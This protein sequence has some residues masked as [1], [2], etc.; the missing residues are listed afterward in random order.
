MPTR[1]ASLIALLC[2]T[3]IPASAQRLPTIVTPEHYDLAF[4]VDL[5]H[6]RFEGTETIKLRVAEPTRRIVLNAVELQIRDVTIGAGDTAQKGTVAFDEANQTVTLS[7]PKPI[8]RG[9]SEI[10]LH[11]SG[12]LNRQLRGFYAIQANARPSAVLQFDLA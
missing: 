8:G 3:A 9:A 4:V 1:L 7:V 10:Q 12:I 6:E 5:K 2:L 11:F